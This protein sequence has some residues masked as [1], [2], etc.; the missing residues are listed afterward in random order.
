[1]NP[2]SVTA[3]VDHWLD[4]MV[5]GLNL[6]PFAR[7]VRQQG[8]VNI[9]VAKSSRI[10]SCLQTLSDE[11]SL[12]LAGDDQA[13][14]LLVLPIGFDHFDDYLDLL[15][16]ANALLVDLDYEGR[17]QLA[18]FHPLYQ[19]DGT[20]VDDVSNWTNRAPLPIVHLLQESSLSRAV[21]AHPDPDSI[22][23]RNIQVLAGLGLV[24]IQKL[25]G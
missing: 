1:M 18:S 14:T 19:F 11:A 9:V 15:A 13:T 7:S 20:S 4:T 12:L 25:L 8:L 21:D 3:L 17:L 16:L 10:E 22:P 23:K 2:E 5:L 6:C 24:G